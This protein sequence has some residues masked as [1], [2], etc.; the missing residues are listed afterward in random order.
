MKNPQTPNWKEILEEFNASGLSARKFAES[1]GISYPALNY[2]IRK[3]RLKNYLE[4][5]KSSGFIQIPV[6]QPSA[7]KALPEITM[8]IEE[9]NI[10]IRIRFEP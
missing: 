9:R 6:S 2:R 3:S 1:I 8:T 5:S 7:E 10:T 4:E